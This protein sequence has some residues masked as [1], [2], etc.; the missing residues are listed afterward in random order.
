MY[1][2][3]AL[4]YDSPA[5]LEF[6]LATE[7]LTADLT[8][9]LG[10]AP[11]RLLDLGCGS[12]TFAL[13]MAVAGWTVT[14]LDLSPAMI[15]RAAAKAA[16]LGDRAPRFVVGDLRR[17]ELLGPFDLVTCFRETLNHLATDADLA[18]ALAGVRRVIAP[19]G[20]FLFDTLT[21]AAGQ[22][23]WNGRIVVSE[24]PDF[25]TATRPSYDAATRTG[26]A[27][28]TIFLRED[29]RYLRFEDRLTIRY[30]PTDQIAEALLAAGFRDVTREGFTPDPAP[31]ETDLRDLW[32]ARPG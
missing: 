14:G 12:G 21:E 3:L 2:A 19:G 29:D 18:P 15:A 32:I 10:L 30:F 8:A 1:R 20:L 24:T 23:L 7:R 11:G 25:F 28:V 26:S 6:A 13:E 31:L 9:R 5:A 16:A 27:E 4:V 22:L 17:I